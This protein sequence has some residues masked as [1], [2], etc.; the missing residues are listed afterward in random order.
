MLMIARQAELTAVQRLTKAVG[1]IIGS[2][3]YTPVTG[4]VLMAKHTVVPHGK[5][6]ITTAA[7]NGVTAMYSD[8]FIGTL[9]DADLRFLICHETWHILY[10]HLTTYADLWKLDADCANAACDYVINM[11]LVDHDARTQPGFITMPKVGLYDE[12][13]RGM[14]VPQ[15]FKALYKQKKGQPQGQGQGQ[16]GQGQPQP[17][18][19]QGQAPGQSLDKHDWEGAGALTAEQKKDLERAVQEAAQQGALLA[20]KTGSGGN[21][22]LDDILDSKVDWKEVL[23]EFITTTCAGN[24]YSTWARPNRRYWGAGTYL[25]SGIS[26]KVDELVIAVDMSGSIGGRMVAQF[27][28]EVAGI[29]ESVNPAAVRILYWDTEVCGD[30]VY[31]D[32]QIANIIHSTKP[33]GGGG[34]AVSCVST[35]LNA[36]G[37]TPQAVIVL[38]DGYLGSDWG[39]WTVPVLWCIVDYASRT[40]PNGTTVHVEFD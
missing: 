36:Q 28:G 35:Y 34:T 39:T 9:T 22:M 32:D 16:P 29:C 15:V 6:G 24:D 18:Q 19:G 30:E 7:T 23:R 4:L 14:T 1:A 5:D 26:Q 33:A 11:R 40:A 2:P 27:M 37:I 17:G 10:L 21:R 25:P 31:A 13:Y 38:T 20:G 3:H 8:E 12:Q